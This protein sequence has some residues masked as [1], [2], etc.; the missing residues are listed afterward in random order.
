MGRKLE[1][2]VYVPTWVLPLLA[3]LLW[4]RLRADR[5]N[6]LLRFK[7]DTYS[8]HFYLRP[9]ILLGIQIRHYAGTGLN[10]R[11]YFSYVGFN[12]ILAG[13]FFGWRLHSLNVYRF[14]TSED[15]TTPIEE[16]S[17]IRE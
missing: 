16:A 14:A 8:H 2:V 12:G 1:I 17:D 15:L 11:G 6:G 13:L 5:M 3:A 7:G 4:I 10:T 9:S